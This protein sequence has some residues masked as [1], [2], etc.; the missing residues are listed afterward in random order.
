VLVVVA[1]LGTLMAMG[2]VGGSLM[3]EGRL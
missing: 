2:T 1:L 3:M